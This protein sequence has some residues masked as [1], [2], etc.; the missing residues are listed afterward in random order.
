ME[1]FIDVLNLLKEYNIIIYMKN[2]EYKLQLIEYEIRELFRLKL[3]SD[4]EFARALFIIK[5][6]KDMYNKV[7]R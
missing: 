3:I 7:G 5:R 4:E 1:K 6:E 2:P